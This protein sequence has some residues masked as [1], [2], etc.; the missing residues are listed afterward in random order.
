[1]D[2]RSQRLLR[3]RGSF[4]YPGNAFQACL[5][6]W[7]KTKAFESVGVNRSVLHIWWKH[8][9]P[10]DTNP[11]K[12]SVPS[13][14]YFWSVELDRRMNCYWFVCWIIAQGPTHAMAIYAVALVRLHRKKHFFFSK[15]KFGS[16][17]FLTTQVL[18]R[19]GLFNNSVHRFRVLK[20]FL[21]VSRMSQDWSA[22]HVL[23]AKPTGKRPRGRPMTRR[24]DDISGLVWSCLSV[25]TPELTE[26]VVGREV[27]RELLR[28]LAPRPSQEKGA[29]KWND[30][31]YSLFFKEKR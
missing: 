3:M 20:E 28:F 19:R 14:V 10:W 16:D 1:M 22:R 9:K 6:S 29:W 7:N 30:K 12:R 26:I 4:R 8:T 17:F 27:F 21:Y 2:G 31:C 18:G 25:E 15:K 5:V 11:V 23:L 24:S 13:T